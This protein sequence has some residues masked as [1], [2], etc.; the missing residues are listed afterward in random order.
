MIIMMIEVEDVNKARLYGV[1]HALSTMPTMLAESPEDMINPKE[2]MK[3][4]ATPD[5][6]EQERMLEDLFE[7]SQQL[8]DKNTRFSKRMVELLDEYVEAGYY[9]DHL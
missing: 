7:R 8:Y 4:F 6:E 3:A 9:S 5:Q 1:S 2:Y